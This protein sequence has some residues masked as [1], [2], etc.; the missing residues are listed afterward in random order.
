MTISLS[1]YRALWDSMVVHK[2]KAVGVLAAARKIAS[3]RARYE[4]VSRE[5]GVPWYV[6]GIIHC[7][8]CG[9]DFGRHLHNGDP[10]T[11]KT[12]Q[13][14]KGRPK[15]GNPP[16]SWEHSAIDALQY[17]QLH[18]VE[19]WSVERICAELEAYN[20]MGYR[21]HGINSPYLWSYT[22]HYERGKYISDG[23]WSA[24]AVSQQAGAM[25]LLKALI[26]NGDVSIG[27]PVV[28][29]EDGPA[30]PAA[31]PK[32]PSYA[33]VA[34]QSK[35]FWMQVNAFLISLGALATNTFDRAASFVGEM[36]GIIPE[37][38]DEIAKLAE[39]GAQTAGHLGLSASSIVVPIVMATL[40]IAAWRHI[41]DKREMSQ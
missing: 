21:R 35:S 18:R 25:A 11:A 40:V 29:A 13:V 26:E 17:D 32:K 27:V 12:V 33:E 16:Y 20:G 10:L 24:T 9:L 23:K 37:T 3:H 15:I 28:V 30:W 7:M 14:P 38:K 6:V 2:A 39:G 41:R 8:E 1:E 22:N 5:T 36:I 4:I 31:E 34:V 19:D